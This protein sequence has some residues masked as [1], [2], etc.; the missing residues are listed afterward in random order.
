[1]NDQTTQTAARQARILGGLHAGARFELGERQ[2]YV[3]GSDP[4]CNVVLCDPEVAAEHCVLTTTDEGILCRA[5]RAP[6]FID[7]MELAPGQSAPVADFQRIRCGKGLLAVGPDMDPWPDLDAQ[8]E[9]STETADSALPARWLNQAR[10]WWNRQERPTVHVLAVGMGV[11]ALG[12]A[13]LTYAAF[14]SRPDDPAARMAA[15][16]QWLDAVSPAGS[17]LEIAADAQGRFTIS[18]YIPSSYQ[19]E[20][21]AAA[22]GASDFHPR[23]EIYAV[24]QMLSSLTRLAQLEGIPC[25]PEYAGAGKAICTSNIPTDQ[26]A[27]QLLSMVSQIPGLEDLTLSVAPEPEPIAGPPAAPPRIEPVP[28]EPGTLTRKFSVFITENDRYLFGEYMDRY[29]EGDMFNGFLIKRIEMDR[30]TFK[31]DGYEYQ[32]YVAALRGH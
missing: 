24:D 13:G 1:M 20:L 19:R 4:S 28:P 2:S 5:V 18:G 26:D 17:E 10:Q 25:T 9:S 32:F 15:A 7:Q 30:V 11:V 31:R 12:I 6:V 14:S 22:A 23:L 16:S 3:I 27:W 8:P 29:E 21:L